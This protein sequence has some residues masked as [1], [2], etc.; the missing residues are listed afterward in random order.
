MTASA[1]ICWRLACWGAWRGGRPT[2]QA[3]RLGAVLF[4]ALAGAL[5]W[6]WQAASRL[7]PRAAVCA[8]ILGVVA[9][10]LVGMGTARATHRAARADEVFGD[11]DDRALRSASVRAGGAAALA[12]AL[13][14]GA[15][16]TGRGPVLGIAAAAG[17]ALGWVAAAG[18]GLAARRAELGKARPGAW[19]RQ[20]HP[21]F[22][23]PL[24]LLART[25][26]AWVAS[27]LAVRIA[28]E[29]AP[30]AV[31]LVIGLG[32]A[33]TATAATDP[34]GLLD[35]AW[36]WDGSGTAAKLSRPLA[37]LGATSCAACAGLWLCLGTGTSPSGIAFGLRSGLA[38]TFLAFAARLAY[39]G[40][41]GQRTRDGLVFGAVAG[42]AAQVA[43]PLALLAGLGLGA[44]VARAAI[45][46]ASPRGR[47]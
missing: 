42:L 36:V 25:G 44:H 30:G 47:G 21:L 9:C 37:L 29:G 35:P 28:A 17:G 33:G 38:A 20:R 10:W 24:P 22:P 23:A 45:R 8:A 46:R 39:A 19:R 26:A 2:P 32:A 34:S 16:L 13:A 18:P 4:V 11:V 43:A 6:S 1:L 15:V 31:P 5:L 3:A 12:A 41:A 27:L 7:P 40:R 14:L